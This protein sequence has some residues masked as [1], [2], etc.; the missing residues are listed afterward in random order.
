MKDTTKFI[1]LD[2]SKEKIAVAIADEGRDTPRYFGMI[3]N[4][5][6]DLRKLVMKLGD[7]SSLKVCYEAGST[8]YGI[9][10]LLTSIGVNSE[11]IAHA[12]IPIRAGDRVQT[13]RITSCRMTTLLCAS[14]LNI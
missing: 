11:V 8:G 2:V 7:T 6:E 13:E 10:R 14:A 9:Y 3:D 1:G 12:I 5:P 4:I